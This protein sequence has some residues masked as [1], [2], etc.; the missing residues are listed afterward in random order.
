MKKISQILFLLLTTAVISFGQNIDTIKY[1]KVPGSLYYS[2]IGTDTVAK[3][4]GNP[5]SIK[6]YLKIENTNCRLWGSCEGQQDSSDL[7]FVNTYDLDENLL[8][9]TYQLGPEEIFFG[10]YKEYYKNGKIKIEGQYMFYGTDR[11]QYENRKHWNNKTGEWKYYNEDG[12]LI[13][14][15]KFKNG[16]LKLF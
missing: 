12:K 3:L 10:P 9:C 14:K 1:Y 16:H 11:K 15:R 13:K 7:Y 5:I 2:I 6:E 8:Y 4:N